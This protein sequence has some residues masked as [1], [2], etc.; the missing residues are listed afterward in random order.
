M[1]K[2]V[3]VRA[4]KPTTKRDVMVTVMAY[5]F[6]IAAVAMLTMHTVSGQVRKP[7]EDPKLKPRPVTLR[8]KDGVNLVAAYFPSDKEKD[9]VTVM[10]V[11]EWQGQ[12]GPYVKLVNALRVAGCAVLVPDYRG[13]G[14]SRE[15]VDSRGVTKKFNIATMSK[16][17]IENIVKYD[18]E[19]AKSFLKKENNAGLLNMN[20]MVVIGI[21]EGC[22][23]GGYWTVRD[24]KFPSVGSVKQ[25]QDVK[26]LVLISP[27]KVVKGVPLD[28]ILSDS[29]L[30]RLPIM[31]VGGET[32]PEAEETQRIYNRV[33]I[34]KKKLSR[35]EAQ[36]L[37]LETVKSSLSGHALVNQAA[38]V[39]PAI[40][41]F[42]TDSVKVS[43]EENPWVERQ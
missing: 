26:A 11:H 14:G 33:E 25:G 29:N 32:S 42:V 40:V 24:W 27:E 9:A 18:L 21:Q 41:K 19:A 39:I 10:I 3:A 20:A 16:R 22:V 6:A 35:G 2:M 17:D 8:T 34:I 38:N 5:W 23:M 31:L 4:E 28:P 36:G 37:E 12:M 13:H 15:Y 30:L 43:E 7:P 1:N